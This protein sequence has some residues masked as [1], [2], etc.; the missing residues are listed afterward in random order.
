MALECTY[1]TFTVVESPKAVTRHGIREEEAIY[2]RMHGLQTWCP[3]VIHRE[4]RREAAPNTASPNAAPTIVASPLFRSPRPCNTLSPVFAHCIAVFGA[5]GQYTEF[6]VRR[7]LATSRLRALEGAED[8]GDYTGEAVGEG[9]ERRA[10]GNTV[11]VT[12]FA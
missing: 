1:S 3:D 11:F 12:E 7:A 10:R 4:R 8:F 6:R 2:Q 5:R 9:G